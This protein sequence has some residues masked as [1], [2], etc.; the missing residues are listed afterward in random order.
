MWGYGYP[1]GCCQGN[2]ND[3]FGSSWAILIIIFIIFFCFFGNNRG[4]CD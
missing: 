2:N 3:G 4:R 1:Y